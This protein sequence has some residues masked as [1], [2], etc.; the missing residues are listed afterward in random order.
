MLSGSLDDFTLPE[1]LRMLA[2]LK[3]TGVLNVT[4][5][6][7]SG[8]IDF[9]DGDVVYAET[10][11]SKSHLGQKLVSSGKITDLQ[12]RQSLDVQATTGDRLG[13]ILIVSEA[14]S[15]DDLLE[16][17]R[18]QIE[19]A[20]YELLCWEAGDFLWEKN[21]LE[22]VEGD[23]SL[24]VEDLIRDIGGRLEEREVMRRRIQSPTAVPRMAE[25]P[26]EG[27]AGINITP[28]QWS[29][30]VLVDGTRDVADIAGRAS[31]SVEEAGQSLYELTSSGLIGVVDERDEEAP[32][33]TEDPQADMADPPQRAAAPTAE[34][35]GT[36]R[37]QTASGRDTVPEDWF[38]DPIE[39]VASPPLTVPADDSRR[40][41]PAMPGA[42]DAALQEVDAAL[43]EPDQPDG[44]GAPAEEVVAFPTSADT[45]PHDAGPNETLPTVD[46]AA[47]VR[48]FAGLFD[49]PDQFSKNSRKGDD[50][51]LTSDD[52]QVV[53]RSKMPERSSKG[54]TPPPPPT[55]GRLSR[56]GRR[57][58]GA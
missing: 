12:L 45:V 27:A 36:P 20:A 40:V 9:R 31:I 30:L 35:F 33:V 14:V 47:A 42:F 55:K 58:P 26:P 38:E 1:V 48:E 19:D 54:R 41:A 5:R 34:A 44:Q 21:A 13:H 16:A 43:Q 49:D 4:R 7:G 53:E 22:P 15:K 24:S 46:R 50:E 28:A 52:P 8:R 56:F 6:A 10:E 23:I 2:T 18:A 17:V 3:K 37:A 32:S 51:P 11:L 57:N 29:V 25:R 39:V